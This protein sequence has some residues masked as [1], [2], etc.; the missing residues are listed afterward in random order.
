MSLFPIISLCQTP[1]TIPI[2]MSGGEYHCLAIVSNTGTFG[3][4]Y[5]IDNNGANQFSGITAGTITG[6]CAGAHDAWIIDGSGNCFGLGDNQNGEVGNGTPAGTPVNT[7]SQLTTDSAGNSFTGIIQIVSGTLNNSST[8]G[9]TTLY[10]KSNGTVW[11][12]GSSLGGGRGI[13]GYTGVVNTT[14]PVQVPG[15]SNIVQIQM[16]EICAARNAAGTILLWGGN[17]NKFNR[18][19][20]YG[21][22]TSSPVQDVPTAVVLPAPAVDMAGGGVFGFYA[23][24]NNGHIYAWGKYKGLLGSGSLDGGN[25]AYQTPMPSSPTDLT[26]ADMTSTYN[27][28]HPIKHIYANSVA[29]YALLTDSTLW[30]WGDDVVGS[31]AD[32]IEPDYSTTPTPWFWNISFGNSYNLVRNAPKQIAPGTHNWIAVFASNPLNYFA[33]FE[34]VYGDV[35]GCG[36]NKGGPV[37]NGIVDCDATTGLEGARPTS[38]DVTFI[39]KLTVIG[40]SVFGQSCPG[41]IGNLGFDGN[42]SNCSYPSGNTVTAHLTATYIGNNK[43]VLD[44]STSSSNQSLHLRYRHTQSSGTTYLPG[45][46]TLSK[47]TIIVP[48]SGTYTAQVKVTDIGWVSNT[49]SVTFT[50][51]CTSCW[52]RPKNGKRYFHNL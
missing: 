37:G 23:L 38:W 28:P 26:P 12:T 36:R 8:G 35:Y 25:Q 27:F 29:S 9:W 40:G 18:Q 4:A 42:C 50:V 11:L 43:V 13:S 49:A 2:N 17:D 20:D 22:S 41:C 24:L 31:L 16:G 15:L 34:N 47:D 10:L 52:V 30:S 48:G 44:A 6:G 5:G 7:M 51:G 21:Q 32:G 45:V 39:E 14:R 1:D 33:F 3:T 46:Q 19:Y